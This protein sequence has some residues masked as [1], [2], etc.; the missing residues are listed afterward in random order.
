[1]TNTP[2]EPTEPLPKDR[3][4]IRGLA[5]AGY[6]TT[7]LGLVSGPV[8]ARAL[9]PGGRG[10]VASA[11]AFSTIVAGISSIGVPLAVG[12]AFGA[13]THPRE[14]VVGT[15]MRVA[16]ALALPI[17][18]IDIV[19][20]WGPLSGLSTAGR[21]GAGLL[22]LLAPLNIL[23]N[24]FLAALVGKGS[25][26]SVARLRALPLL[27]TAVA[28]V[29]AFLLGVLS[30][31]VYLGFILLSGLASTFYAYRRLGVRP[32]G[33]VAMKPFLSFGLRG[34]LGN[35]A[36][37]ATLRIDQ[38]VIGPTLGLAKLGLYA[39][40]VTIATAPAT[41]AMAIASRAFSQTAASDEDRTDVASSYL[42]LTLI[43]ALVGTGLLAAAS[44]VFLPLLYGK[45]FRPALL[46]LLL[47]LPGTVFL[48]LSATA[49]SLLIAAGFPGR[50][51]ACEVTG[52]IVAIVGLPIV[53]PIW[54]ISGAATLSTVAYGIS[55]ASYLV[56]LRRIGPVSVRP[57]MAEVRVLTDAIRSTTGR[58]WALLRRT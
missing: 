14:A 15:V 57:S 35:L 37:A 20:L 3:G 31:G 23:T 8:L 29:V 18:L 51:T 12:H 1:M 33:S 44:P 45:A 53:I 30:V 25:L 42:R 46:P 26:Q 56:A 54:G 41:F 16:A 28:T 17:L 6:L 24:S 4:S 21:V 39:I 58:S 11:V 27:L 7:A 19:L 55:C 9:G 13:G 32:R 49:A 10:D 36:L 5:G 47:L 48:C 50:T 43:V 40:A 38:A 52:F 34:Y 2:A 22:I